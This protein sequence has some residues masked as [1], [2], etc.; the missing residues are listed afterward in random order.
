MV[1]EGYQTGQFLK[2]RKWWKMPKLKNSNATFWVISNKVFS[3]IFHAFFWIV[4]KSLKYVGSLNFSFT[5][6]YKNVPLAPNV[7]PPAVAPSARNKL[8][9]NNSNEFQNRFWVHSLND[10]QRLSETLIDFHRLSETLIDFQ[11]LSET[12]IDF[13]R[14]LETLTDF[15]RL[16]DTFKD[17]HRLW[18]TFRDFQR[19]VT[20]IIN[21]F[22][23]WR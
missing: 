6:V 15:Q 3:K 17:S 18:E 21:H 14:L 1:K 8:Q 10:F 19:N 12:L 22:E 20:F 5:T 11:R 7:G 4:W 9:K 13:Q 23:M 2:D 16:S